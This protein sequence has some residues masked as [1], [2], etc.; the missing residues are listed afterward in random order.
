MLS[1]ERKLSL[2]AALVA[3]SLIVVAPACTGFFVNQ[4]N[5][6]A[7]TTAAGASTFS[8][9]P[10]EQMK[11][12]ATYTSSTKDVTNSATW[13]SS[14][15]CVTVNSSGLVVGAGAATNVTITATLGGVSGSITGTS[16]GGTGGQTLTIGPANT[17]TFTHG[18]SQ[19]FTA[20]LNNIDVTSTATWT[21]SDT[22]VVTFSTTTIGDATFVAAG[23]ATISA[24]VLSGSTCAS[25]SES[26]TVQ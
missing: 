1:S 2:L 23:T 14:S 12:T 9:P 25:G 13:G 18:T 16:T 21:S 10:S 8:V 4:P 3:L 5:S 22:S 17:T 19:P 24:S 26:I 7:V 20:T 11:A 6:I 15:A